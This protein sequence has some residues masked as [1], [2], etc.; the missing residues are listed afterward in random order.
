MMIPYKLLL[1]LL[2]TFF[3]LPAVHS[4]T[5]VTNGLVTFF[6][7]RGDFVGDPAVGGY[8]QPSGAG[9]YLLWDRLGTPTNSTGFFGGGEYAVQETSK[10]PSQQVTLTYSCW[11]KP[12]RIGQA[13]QCLFSV[14]SMDLAGNILPNT[15][16][17]LALSP[18]QSNLFLVY[19]GQGN[20]VISTQ[21]AIGTNQWYH[22]A[23]TKTSQSVALFVDGKP[24]GGGSTQAG[25]RVPFRGDLY[26]GRNGSIAGEQY[27]GSLDEL[28]VYNRALSST[29]IRELYELESALRLS[30]RPDQDGVRLDAANL[31]IGTNYQFQI[32]HDLSDWND[33]GSPFQLNF[34]STTSQMAAITNTSAFWRL[35]SLP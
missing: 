21:A 6:P 31:L 32:S 27:Y 5:W 8:A 24:R 13:R 17:G 30:I 12:A 29:E 10:H 33:F 25:Q 9:A 15:R 7:F 22:L 34:W 26:I 1:S 28:R 18:G 19:T 35:K 16:S 4:Q 11:V 3:C 20:D 14:A 23:L 2:L